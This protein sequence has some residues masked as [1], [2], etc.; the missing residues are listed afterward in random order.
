M[1][2]DRGEIALAA[3]IG[4]LVDAD[5]DG[6]LDLYVGQYLELSEDSGSVAQDLNEIGQVVET[7]RVLQD[8]TAPAPASA[9][10]T[11]SLR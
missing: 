8:G 10:A 9:R 3:A 7:V 11:S 4:D 1:V 6:V 2:D 5:R